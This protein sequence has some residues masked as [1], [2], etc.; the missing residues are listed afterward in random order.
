MTTLTYTQA[1]S[2]SLPRFFGHFNKY[3]LASIVFAILFIS[4][5]VLPHHGVLSSVLQYNVV[6][7][8]FIPLIA[9]A[10]S[11][12]SL[13][14]IPVTHDRG[15]T[16]S[17]ITLGITGLYFTVALAVPFVLLGLY[18]IYSYLL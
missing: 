17:Y 11:V 14:Q 10:L 2:A 16:L 6:F 12:I 3:A 8:V 13:R 5:F 1:Q 7:I 9:L 15:I 18:F 4:Y